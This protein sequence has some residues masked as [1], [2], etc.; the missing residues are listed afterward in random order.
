MT[1]PRWIL[2]SDKVKFDGCD[3]AIAKLEPYLG[4]VILDPPADAV[5]SPEW[6][7][8][9]LKAEIPKRLVAY[10]LMLP[11]MCEAYRRLQ[12]R[13]TSRTI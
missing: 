9:K 2:G 12:V 10:L 11:D 1:C 5:G 8:L 13:E 4:K 3:L 7:G 6:I